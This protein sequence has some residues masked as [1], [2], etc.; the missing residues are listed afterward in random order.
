ME[1]KPIP[2]ND[3]QSV[4]MP[5]DFYADL[6][7]KARAL[8]L[9]ERALVEN[10]ALNYCDKMSVADRFIYAVQAILPDTYAKMAEKVAKSAEEE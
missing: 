7:V 10:A 5:V 2:A 4:T 3:V 6:A 8:E 9:L 1:V